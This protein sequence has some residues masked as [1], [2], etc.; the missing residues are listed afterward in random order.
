M[1]NRGKHDR[2]QPQ[3]DARHSLATVLSVAFFLLILVATVLFGLTV[4]SPE[5]YQETP[6]GNHNYS[7]DAMQQAV[8][9]RNV[10]AKQDDLA[11]L[12]SRFMGQPGCYA[13]EDYIRNAFHRAGLEVYEQENW[14]VVPKTQYR[15]I[16]LAEGPVSETPPYW[17]TPLSDVQVYPFMPNHL[18]P[19]TTPDEGIDGRLVALSRETIDSE[20]RFDD[21]IGLLDVSEGKVLDEYGYDWTR[22]AR[23]GL[24]GLIVAHPDGL[25]AAPWRRIAARQEGMVSGVPINF[26]RLAATEGIF[27]YVGRRV[28][29]R[30]R[31]RFE[32]VKNTT[33]VG[34]LRA[35][36]T[37]SRRRLPAVQ[38][39]TRRRLPA[40]QPPTSVPNHD[41]II[42]TSSYDAC[43]IL[44]D[45]APGT[46]QAVWPATQLALVEGIA[47]YRDAL[48][49][50]VVFVA[51]GAQEMARDGENNLLRLLDENIIQK[52]RNPFR[53][54][55]RF[56]VSSGNEGAQ[57]KHE[58]HQAARVDP[59]VTRRASNAASLKM[60]DAITEAASIRPA[61]D[62]DAFQV[63][64][65]TEGS[66]LRDERFL[67]EADGT[68][69]ILQGFDKPTRKFLDEQVRYVLN[70]FVFEL[71]EAKLRDKLAFLH[72][73]DQDPQS[74]AFARY[75]ETR[76]EHDRMANISGYR[77]AKLVEGRPRLQSLLDKHDFRQR[78]LDRFVELREYHARKDRCL[79]KDIALIRA[80]NPYRDLVVFDV[81]MLPAYDA[82][83][84][85]EVLSFSNGHWVV[86]AQ[87]HSMIS[88]MTAARQRLRD[89]LGFEDIEK[90][91]DIPPLAKL[92]HADVALHTQPLPDRSANMWTQ[93]GYLS[94]KLLSF[95]RSESYQRF[96]DP[97]DLPLMHNMA[98]LKCSLAVVG[99]TILS[100]AHGNGRF[101]PI[102]VGWMK[103]QFGGRVLASGIGQS[104]APQYPL[105]GAVLG[106]RPFFGYEY[107]WPGYYDQLLIMTDPYGRY[108]IVNCATDFWVDHYIW[109]NGYSP[110]AV[111]YGEDGR[112]AWM[113][114]EGE[115]G[116]RLYKSVNLNWFKGDVD[117][118]T[119][120]AFRAAPVAFLDMTN[121]Q[122]MRDYAAV[123]LIDNEG[124]SPFGK[125]CSFSAYATW[126]HYIEPEERLYALFESGSSENDLAKV[127]RAF[128]FGDPDP[129]YAAASG[130]EREADG[131]G[132]LSS[133]W[134]VLANMQHEIARSMV[135]LNGKRLAL[136][137]RHGMVDKQTKDFHRKSE[138]LLQASD[139]PDAPHRRADL[140]AKEAVVYA[141]L[142]HPVLRESIVEAVIGIM[143][144]LALLVPFVY[145]LEKLLFCFSDVRKQ[146][147]AQTIVFLVAF[148]LLR[149]L[150]PAFEM[151]RSSLM[152][153][154]GFVVM[155]ISGGMSILFSGKFKENLED[156]RKRRGRV[157]AAEVSRFGVIG[158]AFMLGLNNMHRRR[159]RTWLTCGTLTL[160]TFAMICFTSVT[161]D[162]A[163]EAKAIGKAPYQGVLIKQKQFRPFSQAELF[164]IRTRFSDTCQV[165]LRRVHLGIQHWEDKRG[166]N[167]ELEI[168]NES[169]SAPRN[170]PFYSVVHLSHA[171]PLQGQIRMLTRT[172]WFTEEQEKATETVC[173]IFIPDAMAESLGISVDAVNAG[174]VEV[175]VNGRAFMVACIFEA[176]SLDSLVD[177]DGNSIMPYNIENMSRIQQVDN[178]VVAD[179]KDPRIRARD[180][181]IAPLRN[182]EI[183]IPD[184]NDAVVSVALAMPGMPYKQARET[185]NSYLE[186][187]GKPAYYG[188]D[189]VA[190]WGK[191]TRERSVV[192]VVDLLIPLLIAAFTVLN[193]MRGSV[194]ERRDEI[195]VYNAVGIAPRY[196]FFIFFAESFVYAVVGSVLGYL[197]SQGTGQVLT[198][199]GATGGMNMSFTSSTTI[200]ASFAVV[201]AALISTYFPARSAVKIAQPAE[202]AGWTLPEPE[203]DRIAFDLP[204]NYD[205][206]D[207]MA[208]VVFF[209][210]LL[211]DHGEGGSGR[212]F[213]AEPRVVVRALQDASGARVVLPELT[214][215]VWLKPFDLSVSQ[216]IELRMPVDDETGEFKASLT[217]TRLSG[218]RE[219]WL[220]LNHSFVAEVRRHFLH[221]RAV[222]AKDRE[223][224]FNEIHERVSRSAGVGSVSE[225]PA[226]PVEAG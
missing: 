95:D 201:A 34:I 7:M 49:R 153:L 183:Q 72:I 148:G 71:Y 82:K 98:S 180:V 121:P 176:A 151:V 181:I 124:L 130:S 143:W 166:H 186:Q 109:A 80:L 15:E 88:M 37:S 20:K 188:I 118:V 126:V 174:P 198:S 59:W 77:I 66:R 224:M 177:L 142:D 150:H 219:A 139:S 175:R 187:T 91:L 92:H 65:W 182:L 185:I 4:F 169:S 140:K 38:P 50:D 19:I 127:V 85:G 132:Y 78:C 44:P 62:I 145:F 56:D 76:S 113:K 184:D 23:L 114:D 202:E 26:L 6:P 217:L 189:G 195:E 43:S 57:F 36:G 42:I 28:R 208:V 1:L 87:M 94:F 179:E 10:Q 63:G 35:G 11:A 200:Y 222:T 141:T 162:I 120:V 97:I 104:A 196:I 128:A 147:A 119:V 111:W 58:S 30:V 22:Y 93:F 170:V 199:L 81:C 112:I 144:Y 27:N 12:G 123:R 68:A 55:F 52:E 131:A 152:I 155:L 75:L 135:R 5:P 9:W 116:Q 225:K 18:Q 211:L 193:T 110:V 89:R 46:L 149:L 107:S 133:D 101:A 40:V 51:F 33:L 197:L 99:E 134:P 115:D 125:R 220:R 156:L 61:A 172:P 83:P 157:D 210:R 108:E 212:F 73:P 67:R 60:I 161:S 221:W 207:R 226:L 14:T 54:A 129:R 218:A 102:Q 213:A 138:D 204:F 117:D 190:Y 86:N 103:K 192:G 41:A 17:G 45:L 146:V 164:A 194:Y 215:P 47:P 70:T 191:R 3:E 205:Y 2:P 13:A 64:G 178:K 84:R 209:E 96:A 216:T 167:P 32:E 214:C 168:V 29:V 105:K 79:E 74:A 160:I 122:T 69:S 16:Y 90:E 21:C 48:V 106:S 173:P 223:S 25:A 159:M 206:R 158:S 171:D 8:D 163:E 24:K 100:L 137:D 136:Q 39:P 31:M 53:K 203:D 165:C 154:L